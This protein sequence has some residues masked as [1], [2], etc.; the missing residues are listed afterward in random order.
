MDEFRFDGATAVISGAGRGLGRAHAV[1]LAARGARVVVAD[2]ARDASGVALAELVA[3]EIVTLGGEA[4]ACVGSVADAG[5]VER[6]V[7][8]ARAAYGGVDVVVNNAGIARPASLRTVT[9]EA[10]HE[11]LA[12]H[13]LGT[14]LLTQAAWMDLGRSGHGA[15]VNTTSGVGLFGLAGAIGYSAAKMAVIGATKVMALEGERH[16]IRVNAIAPMARTAMAGETFGDLTPVLHPDLVASV[17]AWLAHPSCSLNGEVISAGG[18]RVASRRDP[19]RR[20]SLRRRPDT[21]GC[22]PP[23]ADLPHPT[24][25][26]RSRRHGRGRAHPGPPD[27]QSAARSADVAKRVEDGRSDLGPAPEGDDPVLHPPAHRRLHDFVVVRR[28]ADH[29]LGQQR[30]DP[31]T[32]PDTVGRLVDIDVGHE[33]RTRVLGVLV[34]V[35]LDLGESVQAGLAEV[36]EIEDGVL[37]EDLAESVPVPVVDGVAIPARELVQFDAI[38]DIHGTERTCPD[39]SRVSAAVMLAVACL[40]SGLVGVRPPSGTVTFLFTDIEGSTRR[41]EADP[42]AMR[43]ALVLHDE[44]LR[45]VIEAHGG[46]LFKHTGDGV[47]AAFGSARAAIDAAVEAQ[48]TL[49]LPVRM[50]IATGEAERR[51]EDYF[52]PVLNR[53]ARVMAA[54]HGGQ[55]LVAASTAAVVSGVDLIDRGEHRLRDLSGVEH[56]YQVRAAGLRVEFAPLRTLD[57]VPGN[58]PV[59]TTSFVGREIAVKELAEQVRAHRLVTLTGVG[60]VGKTRLAMQVAAELTGEFSDGVWLVELAPVGDPAAVPDT[61][62]AVLGVTPQAGALGDRQ[63]HAGAVG[64]AVVVGVGQ[65]RA[66]VGRRRRR[67]RAAPGPHHD[68]EG[69]RHVPRGAPG[70]SRAAVAGPV[71]GCRRRG[72][73]GG[74][75]VVRRTGPS[76]EPGVRV[77]RRGRLRRR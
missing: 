67:R 1:L 43:A 68:G 76:R 12:V 15:V 33:V 10:L 71:A 47:C 22:G 26:R 66:R 58:L 41:W 4:V 35:A 70:G 7:M 51:G 59:Q 29:S 75:G 42:E 2:V 34:H 27:R 50:G 13:T 65:L 8:T 21:R 31:E 3:K 18:G 61:V 39:A 23:G 25:C 11:E 60:G 9:L 53:T 64:A 54:G 69:D 20:G 30:H 49:G 16:G 6:I 14:I 73:V 52:G 19:G 62:A 77:G 38:S 37:G 40:R 56:L 57:A 55:I 5:D 46:W 48:Q 32:E 28:R 36:G 63:H 74:G 72:R 17:V 44:V 45:S 24:H